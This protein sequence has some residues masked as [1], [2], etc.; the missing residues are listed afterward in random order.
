MTQKLSRKHTLLIGV[1]LFS[2]F[3]G[4]GNL[5]FPPFLGEQA[6]TMAWVAF[7]GFALS[8]IGL[9]ILGV[10]AVAKS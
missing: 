1:T 7:G 10:A 9:P 6:G 3:F 5:I 4:A 8:A 2:M